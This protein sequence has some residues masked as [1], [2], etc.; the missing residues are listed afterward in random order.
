MSLS[1]YSQSDQKKRGTERLNRNSRTIPHCM[2]ITADLKATRRRFS[3]NI[4]LSALH[5]TIKLIRRFCLKVSLLDTLVFV[6]S[7]NMRLYIVVDYLLPASDN[8]DYLLR[9][10]PNRLRLQ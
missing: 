4:A 1:G 8:P 7:F 3:A 9:S 10:R 5:P 6:P 2:G